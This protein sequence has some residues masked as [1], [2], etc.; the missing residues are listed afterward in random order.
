[1]INEPSFLK[2]LEYTNEAIE[3]ERILC[4]SL[5]GRFLMETG[6]KPFQVTLVRKVLDDRIEFSVVKKYE[7]KDELRE[8]DEQMRKEGFN[9]GRGGATKMTNFAE[10]YRMVRF[11]YK[12]VDDYLKTLKEEK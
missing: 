11:M 10:G 6:L 1:M 9:A 5:I 2:L 4:S 12:T 7:A 8:R 3:K